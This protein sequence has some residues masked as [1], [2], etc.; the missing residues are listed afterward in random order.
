MLGRI[1][2]VDE[3]FLKGVKIGGEGLIAERFVEATKVERLYRIP[4]DLLRYEGT[5]VL[6]VKVMN[7]YLNGGIFDEGVTI[8]DPR[9]S[10]CP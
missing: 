7:T 4:G 8:G 1:G 3:V 2:D 9:D 6:A 5:N 10:L